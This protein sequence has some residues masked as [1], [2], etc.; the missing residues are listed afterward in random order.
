MNT[1]KLPYIIGGGI[2]LLLVGF[3]LVNNKKQN[4]PVQTTQTA[5]VTPSTTISDTTSQDPQDIVPGLYKNPIQNT[6]TQE[7]FVITTTAVENNTDTAGK[8]V[9]D[10]LELTLKNTVGKDLT[11]FEVYYTITDP[12]TNKKEGYYKKLT[13]F[14]L[15]SGETQ[16]IHFDN[17]Q[18]NGHFSANK[19]SMYYKSTNKLLFTIMLSTPGY[20]LQTANIEKA[21]GGAEQK[22]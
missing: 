7:G 14:V 21:A 19:N 22:D 20:K 6:A 1:N 2:L 3:L 9:S 5:N 11:D 17:K 16:T 10:H 13:G 4:K 12:T 8:A 15:K 18:G